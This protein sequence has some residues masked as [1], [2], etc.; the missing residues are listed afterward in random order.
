[1][2]SKFISRDILKWF[3]IIYRSIFG[4]HRLILMNI[5]FAYLTTIKSA[6]SHFTKAWT[7]DNA[8][9]DWM[10]YMTASPTQPESWP[11]AAD[12]TKLLTP[13]I[14]TSMI[15]TF[16]HQLRSSGT[17]NSRLS[18]WC[19]CRGHY[20]PITSVGRVWHHHC[21]AAAKPRRRRLSAAIDLYRRP[22]R[23]SAPGSRLLWMEFMFSR[24][25]RKSDC[26]T[27]LKGSDNSRAD[28]IGD[29]VFVRFYASSDRSCYPGS[30][31]LLLVVT[32]WSLTRRYVYL[33]HHRHAR[34]YS[35]VL[36]R[37]ICCR[38]CV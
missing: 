10:A 20:L 13:I 6:I 37:L 38:F 7:N 36:L 35:F 14:R 31:S 30:F 5:N 8:V 3:N 27:G 34:R 32:C 21:P 23:M 4:S 18:L 1:M 12:H 16:E 26:K 25:G 9:P 29:M 19:C 33:I 24:L 28:C 17:P 22:M 11:R 2:Q 15:G